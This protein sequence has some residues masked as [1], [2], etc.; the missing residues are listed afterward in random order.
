MKR[1]VAL[2]ADEIDEQDRDGHVRKP[3]E[4]VRNVVKEDVCFSPPTADPAGGEVGRVEKMGEECG[5]SASLVG[6]FATASGP[7]HAATMPLRFTLR[8][9]TPERGVVI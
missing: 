3:D 2:A 8:P 6:S 1:H 9:G 7:G 5:H 4:S